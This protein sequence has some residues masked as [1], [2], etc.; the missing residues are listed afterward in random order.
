MKGGKLDAKDIKAGKAALRNHI[1]TE[2]ENG[3]AS[4]ESLAAQGLYTGVAKSS[5]ELA[6]DVNSISDNDVQSVSFLC[7]NLYFIVG[8][9]LCVIVLGL[10]HPLI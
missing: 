7:Y 3:T 2:F 10:S 1:L 5:V 9:E 6:N 4:A 8:R